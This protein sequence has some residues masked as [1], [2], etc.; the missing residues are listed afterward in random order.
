MP[1][2]TFKKAL[3]FG[4]ESD[5]EDDSSSENSSSISISGYGGNSDYSGGAGPRYS[6][7]YANYNN[8]EELKVTPNQLHSEVKGR[9]PPTHM[10]MRSQSLT[11]ILTFGNNDESIGQ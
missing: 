11:S 1:S 10:K 2:S 7:S 6:T 4:N 5:D 3:F 9:K 8:H